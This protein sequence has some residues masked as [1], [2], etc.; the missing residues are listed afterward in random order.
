MRQQLDQ[1]LYELRAELETGRK[2]LIELENKETN[3]RNSLKRINDAI[4]VL[5]YELSKEGR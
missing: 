1:R 2:T 3:L 4:E 5:E